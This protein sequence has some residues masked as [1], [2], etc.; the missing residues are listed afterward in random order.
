MDWKKDR[1][2]VQEDGEMVRIVS[3]SDGKLFSRNNP[4]T[5]P[6]TM[7]VRLI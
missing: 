6:S 1:T 7:C 5:Q 2:W 3:K 4:V